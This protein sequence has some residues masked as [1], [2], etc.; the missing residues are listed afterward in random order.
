MEKPF[1]P[2]LLSDLIKTAIGHRTNKWFAEE[3]GITP[4]H[5]SRILHEKYPYPPRKSTLKA[6]AACSE[7]RVSEQSLYEACGYKPDHT[8]E[9]SSL[10]PDMI[11]KRM[12]ATILSELRNK[13][14]SLSVLQNDGAC[15]LCVRLSGDN[16]ATWKFL[17]LLPEAAG[18][19][20]PSFYEL[21]TRL[22][23]MKSDDTCKTSIVTG[24]ENTFTQLTAKPAIN[25]NTDVSFI[26]V[27]YD[28]LMISQEKKITNYEHLNAYMKKLHF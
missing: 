6:I 7:E 19:K 24:D 18:L 12:E 2:R 26:L 3:I 9:S 22:A 8:A 16:E 27:D 10:S 23:Y 17:F 4:A 21:I 1:N 5:L 25:L 20:N 14:A 15:D 13:K 28:N 11:R